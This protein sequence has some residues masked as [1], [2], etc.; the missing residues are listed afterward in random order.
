MVRG[1]GELDALR[2]QCAFGDI[3]DTSGVDHD[4]DGRGVAP[5]E[6]FGRRGADGLLGGQVEEEGSVSHGWVGG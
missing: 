3:H 4:V 1:E 2:T 5:G 6:D